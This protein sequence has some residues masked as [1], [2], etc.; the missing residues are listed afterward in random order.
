MELTL[1]EE[2]NPLTVTVQG[3]ICNLNHK[4]ENTLTVR[5]LLADVSNE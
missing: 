3:S 2:F 5:Y 4:K 1:T